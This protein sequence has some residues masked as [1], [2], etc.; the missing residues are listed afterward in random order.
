L[1]IG[2]SRG[3]GLEFV[4]QYSG[5]GAKVLAT[6]RRPE[7]AQPLRQLGA[8]PIALDVCDDASVA[9]TADR[10]TGS[11]LDVAILNAG[12]YGPRTEA[13]AEPSAA[14]FDAVFHTN[15][16]ATMLL[17]PL[18]APA[19][20]RARG[21]LAV[22]SSSM[23]S[24]SRATSNAGW[25]YRASKAALNAV[26][27]SASLELGPRGVVCMAFDPGWVRTD[28]GG[29]RATLE[30]TDSVAGMRRVVDAAND[31]FNGKFLKYTGEQLA[32]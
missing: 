27:K 32:W 24:I 31:S 6:Y 7:D 17:L 21:K 19:L 23:G 4:R 28:M 13:M 30:V 3:I 1:I 14:D 26:L 5:D 10:L 12:V 18:L 9:A 16:R 15:V 8:N 2:A 11:E 22:I 25:L 20:I 29:P